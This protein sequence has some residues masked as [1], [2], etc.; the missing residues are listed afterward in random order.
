MRALSVSAV[1][2]AAG[3]TSPIMT[4]KHYVNGRGTPA[5]TTEA[6]EALYAV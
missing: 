6:V 3:H 5:K 4:F 2:K 1:Q